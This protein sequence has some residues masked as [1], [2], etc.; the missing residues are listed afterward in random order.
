MRIFM[1]RLIL[2]ETHELFANF[3]LFLV[4]VHILGVIVE[5]FVHRENLA[6]AMVHGSKKPEQN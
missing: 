1:G 3:T 5:S 4:I 2:E 6:K